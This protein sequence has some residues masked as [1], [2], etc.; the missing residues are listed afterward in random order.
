MM[1]NYKEELIMTE[2]AYFDAVEKIINKA[3]AAGMTLDEICKKLEID[4]DG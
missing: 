3:L 4:T 1:M 2:R